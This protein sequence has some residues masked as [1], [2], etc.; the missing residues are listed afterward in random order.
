MLKTLCS[1]L[2]LLLLTSA[3]ARKTMILSDPAGAAVTVDGQQ[4]CVT[5]CAFNYR[6]GKADET[7]QVVLEKKGFDPIRYELKAEEID[8]GVRSTLWTTGLII[9]GGSILWVSS[10]FTNKLKTSYHFVLQ[11]ELPVVAL[12]GPLAQP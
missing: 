5:P 6:T 1:I 2:I 11:E 10:M 9:P 3:C 7:Y 4:V 8:S 12:H